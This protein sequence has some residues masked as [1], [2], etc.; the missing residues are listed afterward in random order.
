M[1][2]PAPTVPASTLAAA[3]DALTKFRTMSIPSPSNTTSAYVYRKELLNNAARVS[4]AL[5]V[6][7]PSAPTAQTARAAVDSLLNA[8]VDLDDAYTYVQQLDATGV[9]YGLWPLAS[10]LNTANR[11]LSSPSRQAQLRDRFEDVGDELAPPRTP[12]TP[13]PTAALRARV[14]QLEA[15]S[16][17]FYDELQACYASQD[18]LINALTNV[19]DELTSVNAQN[20]KLREPTQRAEAMIAKVQ[21]R[22]ASVDDILDLLQQTQPDSERA[23]LAINL[24]IEAS[25]LGDGDKAVKPV[26]DGL[27]QSVADALT[28]L[29]P[30]APGAGSARA[31]EGAEFDA[32]DELGLQEYADA[33]DDEEFDVD[34]LMRE[35]ESLLADVQ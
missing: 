14:V 30:S 11:V 22:T 23:L 1:P 12:G 27:T 6:P 9:V 10:P 17:D 24:V 32:Q 34:E 4:R 13:G 33:D 15:E 31:R 2:A 26:A 18:R 21:D 3:L 5:R 28:R 29:A 35:T 25:D 20:E 8:A 16:Q 19:N 7:L